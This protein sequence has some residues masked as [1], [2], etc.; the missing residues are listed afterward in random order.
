MLV[1]SPHSPQFPLTHEFLPH[2]VKVRTMHLYLDLLV[3]GTWI[4]LWMELGSSSGWN[5]DLHVDGTWN[6][7]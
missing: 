2:Q 3:D 4:F 7:K 5:L 1:A 6:F